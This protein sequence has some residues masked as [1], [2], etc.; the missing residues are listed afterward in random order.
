[1]HAL[2]PATGCRGG[3]LSRRGVASRQQARAS[4][5]LEPLLL[6]STTAA[7]DPLAELLAAVAPLDRGKLAS[8]RDAARV[9][10]LARTLEERF[11]ATLFPPT[12]LAGRWRLVYLSSKELFRQSPFFDSFSAAVGDRAVAESIFRFTNELPMARVGAATQRI[13]LVGSIAAEGGG[14]GGARAASEEGRLVS[15]VELAVG[16]LPFFPGLAGV[17][18]SSAAIAGVK[19]DDARGRYLLSLRMKQTRVTQSLFSAFGGDV[20]VAPVEEALTRLRGPAA[21]RVEYAV[22]ALVGAGGRLRV[23]RAEGTGL[24]MVHMRDEEEF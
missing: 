20:I 19:A 21:A 14:Q 17:V 15:E 18:E 24:M 5:S 2:R 16:E 22:T 6:T 1:M 13:E 10:A 3:G 7:A 8:A 11:P 4:T 23:T 12:T 9:D